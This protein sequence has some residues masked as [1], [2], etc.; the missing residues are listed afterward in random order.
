[1]FTFYHFASY[2][3]IWFHTRI[4]KLHAAAWVYLGDVLGETDQSQDRCCVIAFVGGIG[5]NQ[6]LTM[7]VVGAWGGEKWGVV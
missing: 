6:S 4:A 7:V 5:G 2:L 1:M 3:F